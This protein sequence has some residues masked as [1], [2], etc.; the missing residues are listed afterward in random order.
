MNI[1]EWV[2]SNQ[3]TN[4]QI[5]IAQE[6]NNRGM[7]TFTDAVFAIGEV[8]LSVI[9]SSIADPIAGLA[10]IGMSAFNGVVKGTDTINNVR[11]ALSYVPKTRAGQAAMRNIGETMQ[12]VAEA[13][14]GAE[15]YLGDSALNLT[16]SPFLA[17]AAT[18][19]PTAIESMSPLRGVRKASKLSP[20]SNKELSG[21]T[22]G[23]D[24]VKVDMFERDGILSIS[25]I[26]TPEK[27][28]GQG[29]ADEKLS[30]ILADADAKGIKVALSPSG[31]FGAN[32][33]KLTAWYKKRGFK[34]NKGKSKDFATRETMI[35]EPK[36]PPQ[37]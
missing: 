5:A 21:K 29:F 4:E 18:S 22:I 34:P 13:F 7:E 32:K 36:K 19:I 10:G 35:R 16:G 8:A 27:L 33:N 26:Q 15:N 31:D 17:A 28:R 11:S 23:S 14:T 37:Q 12:P 6:L 2:R 9:T 24:A 20:D 25:R 3:P 1:G 30:Q